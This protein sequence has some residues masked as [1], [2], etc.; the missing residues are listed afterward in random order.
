MGPIAL[1]DKS[2]IQSLSVDESV[3]FDHFFFPVICPLFYV[4]TLADL[5]KRVRQGRTPEQ[6]VGIIADKVPEMS[7]GPCAYHVDL[8]MANLL[9][10]SVPMDGRI[11]T[12]G[13]KLVIADGKVGFTHGVP[14]EAEAFARWQK[15]EFLYV[16]RQFARTW[17]A[18]LN[19]IALE[20]VAAG[21]R[22]M[23]ITP[24]TCR[25]LEEAKQLSEGLLT[26]VGQITSD[27][28]KLAMIV[29]GAPAQYEL[30]VL[31]KWR[32]GG[33]G[34]LADYAPYAAHVTGV[35]LFFQTAVG[36]NLIGTAEVNN[37][38]DIG[39]IF[40]TPFCHVF[41]SSDSLHRRCAPHFL[42]A[43][44]TFVWGPELKA[45]LNRL[46]NYYAARPEEEK[47]Q[48]LMRLA[49]TPPPDDKESL[50][51]QLWDRHLLPLWRNRE[52]VS[53]PRK[54]E[55]D[56]KLIELINRLSSAPEI[57]PTEVKNFEPSNPDFVVIERRVAK[58]RGSWWQLPKD[59]KG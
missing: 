56:S 59:L 43:D 21:M 57:S 50:V 37:R 16:E 46:M 6:E 52:P 47:E 30:L 17:R 13:G 24:Q 32:A 38:T 22:A 2:F 53:L 54:P 55:Q 1:F 4:E 44:Q 45:D 28:I 23:G 20:A 5:E 27:Q 15:R 10:V 49:P 33:G 31:D 29:L 8:A 3:F 58:R 26:R 39:Y 7:G 18:S 35:E 41:V 19:S 42:R 9:G 36:A 25:S 14:P 40:Y 34:T 12:A 51:V 11:P 48:G